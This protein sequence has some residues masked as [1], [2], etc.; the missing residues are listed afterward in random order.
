MTASGPISLT[1]PY[2][3]TT[4]SERQNRFVSIVRCGFHLFLQFTRLPVLFSY[5][6]NARDAH[7]SV[8]N[9]IVHPNHRPRNDKEARIG[10][11]NVA[12]IIETNI[13]FDGLNSNDVSPKSNVTHL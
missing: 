7:T 6:V 4:A 10:P 1:C 2:T 9:G 11:T 5:K 3:P 12:L 8:I 13:P